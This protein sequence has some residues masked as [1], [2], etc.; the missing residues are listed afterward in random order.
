LVF[1][2]NNIL[3]RGFNMT[4]IFSR[5]KKPSAESELFKAENGRGYYKNNELHL[6]C[7][8]LHYIYKF[9]GMCPGW[10][11]Q[12]E[13]TGRSYY[14]GK[15]ARPTAE[16]KKVEASD[17]NFWKDVVNLSELHGEIKE[18]EKWFS[19]YDNQVSQHERAKR[20]GAGWSAVYDGKTYASLIEL[21]A[22][23]DKNQNRISELRS[24]SDN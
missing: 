10:Y 17:G 14:L 18:L 15:D 24:L 12:N 11:M 7:A 8:K 20:A 9:G 3:K 23:A 2:F 6:L 16:L 1:V 19:W 4:Y 5:I 21:D 13:K 22:E